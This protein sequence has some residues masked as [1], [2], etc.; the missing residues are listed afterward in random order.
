M[1]HILNQMHI[2]TKEISI[3]IQKLN[4]LMRTID[5]LIPP[6]KNVVNIEFSRINVIEN[7]KCNFCN[8]ISYYQDINDKYYCWFH[9][10]QYE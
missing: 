2:Q 3:N 7:I 10:S 9:R 1:N 6:K 5:A 4:H 8:K